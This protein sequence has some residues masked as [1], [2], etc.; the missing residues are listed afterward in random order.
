M[1]FFISVLSL[2]SLILSTRVYMYVCLFVHHMCVGAQRIQKRE[3][4]P[5]RLDLL[6]TV[7][8]LIG[9]LG[10]EPTPSAEAVDTLVAGQPLQAY[11]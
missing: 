9:V 10:T 3:S 7:N 1:T 5:L 4:E 2:L 6:A 11:L 8:C